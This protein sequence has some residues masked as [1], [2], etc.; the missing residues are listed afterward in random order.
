MALAHTV[1][2]KVDD[3]AHAALFPPTRATV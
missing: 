2:D 1:G 3:D